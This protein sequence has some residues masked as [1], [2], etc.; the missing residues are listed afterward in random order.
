MSCGCSPASMTPQSPFYP[1]KAKPIL[2]VFDPV[3]N[4]V[5]PLAFGET[6]PIP[7]SSCGGWNSVESIIP[8]AKHM[9]D[10]YFDLQRRLMLLEQK[11]CECIC[12]GET[13]PPPPP[14]DEIHVTAINYVEGSICLTLND[15]TEL[16]A[17]LPIPEVPE[18]PEP[19][20]DSW[21]S[22]VIE[23]TIDPV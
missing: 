12:S 19:A 3:T 2:A 6:P 10:A 17:A 22:D 9:Q 16:C 15:G 1:N 7:D 21:Q 8:P 5:R 14:I 20:P 23:F 11:Y 4:Q 13:A 18:V